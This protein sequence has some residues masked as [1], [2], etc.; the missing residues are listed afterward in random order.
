MAASSVC[1]CFFPKTRDQPLATSS[2][3][4]GV[5]GG[6][7]DSG[8]CSH[9]HLP[10]TLLVNILGANR[11]VS[12]SI[13]RSRSHNLTD[14]HGR[15]VCGILETLLHRSKFCANSEA[16]YVNSPGQAPKSVNQARARGQQADQG[17][18][19]R[20]SSENLEKVPRIWEVEGPGGQKQ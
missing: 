20:K 12:I 19:P 4:Y 5:R 6:P 1:R 11:N 16:D 3:G 8:D 9:K 17:R 2:T 10:E 13:N 7:H 18:T 14:P 15:Y